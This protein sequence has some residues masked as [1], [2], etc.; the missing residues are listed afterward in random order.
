MSKVTVEFQIKG[1]DKVTTTNQKIIKQLVEQ[2]T[3]YKVL[4]GNIDD[5]IKVQNT[6]VE[7]TQELTKSY[8][9]VLAEYKANE[10]ELK[11]LAIAGETT[12][13]RY[14][15]LVQSV[16][17][18]RA[19]LE[20]V[21][22][23]A[24]IN[25]GTF[26]AI[27]GTL[28]GVTAGFT[29]VQGALGILGVESEETE[30]A[31]LKVQSALAL[32]QGIDQFQKAIPAFTSLATLIKGPVVAAFTT[33]RGAII[34]TGIG[35]AV[36]AVGLLIANFD[37]V[38][39]FVSK[40]V[41]S[42]NNL[43][44]GVKTFI[45]I[46]FPL[47][48]I[49]RLVV[50]G[51]QELGIIDDN[52]TRQIRRNAEA[53]VAA[54]ISKQREIR[55]EIELLQARGA[56]QEEIFAAELR[57]INESIFQYEQM[58]IAKGKLNDEEKKDFEAL[59]QEKR[60]LLAKQEKFE[61]D[62]Q[63]RINNQRITAERTNAER[64]IA[65]L[66]DG[67]KKE[68]RLLKL[69]YEQQR[70]EAI[71]NGED[72][73][74]IEQLY[75]KER[76]EIIKKFSVTY[77]NTVNEIYTKLNAITTGSYI[78]EEAALRRFQDKQRELLKQQIANQEIALEELEDNA[79]KREAIDE[80]NLNN[81]KIKL[82]EEKK[83]LKDQLSLIQEKIRVEE[84]FLKQTADPNKS[85]D[86]EES[87]RKLSAKY[88]KTEKELTSVLARIKN[89]NLQE[90]FQKAFSDINKS[91]EDETETLKKFKS[92]LEIQEELFQAQLQ[93]IR[94]E[95]LVD[96]LKAEIDIREKAGQ[97]V[98]QLQ[99]ELFDNEFKIFS[100]NEKRKVRQRAE[101]LAQANGADEEQIKKA[102]EEA[103]AIY[104]SLLGS[105]VNT[106]KQRIKFS[107]DVGKIEKENN[108]ESLDVQ[109]AYYDELNN[110]SAKNTTDRK[111]QEADITKRFDKEELQRQ[112]TILDQKLAAAKEAFG[113]ESEEYKKL[114]LEKA[115]VEKQFLDASLE[116]Q[117]ITQDKFLQLFQQFLST[118]AE[119][120]AA[121][122]SFYELQAAR[123]N[124]FYD[125]EV[126]KNED[127]NNTEVN[128][129]ALTQEEIQNI[130]QRYALQ[131][132]EIERKRNEEI[133]KIEKQ[134]A[135]VAFRLQIAQIIGNG[136]LAVTRAFAELG[137]IAGAVAAA[138]IG[139]TTGAQI[140]T[141]N[142]QRKV[143]QQLEDGGLLV[144]ASHSQ[145]GIPV[146]NT[147]IEVEGNEFVVNKKS[148]AKY[149]PLLEAINGDKSM[150]A[151]LLPR[152]TSFMQNGG[153]MQMSN[154][155][156]GSTV[157]KTYVVTDE[158]TNKQAMTARI[159]RNSRY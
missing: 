37:K 17:N 40:A 89:I 31:L 55:N 11:A 25:K 108:R 100:E 12:S 134:R 131:E 152:T 73:N 103:V 75:S 155:E 69:N 124:A 145:G 157:F 5:I 86:I 115:K 123:T 114:Q 78:V 106:A 44:N 133:K 48:G 81:Q 96:G 159:K 109:I 41:D 154:I 22:K 147:G 107:N 146:G 26:D 42:F 93:A 8:Q 54:S 50:A 9:E 94:V 118:L 140:A 4:E 87:L 27:F 111:K 23:E 3:E 135:D 150:T 43:G 136:A 153:M 105:I 79:K 14:Q 33:L 144:G 139:V 62:E 101:I 20:D 129:Y 64:R 34:A 156:Q 1:G 117:Q 82:N 70:R 113:E 116:Q 126:R 29:A 141:A 122:D 84:I 127:A 46:I 112:K 52:Q 30:K 45:S 148:T 49:L 65:L 61:K 66:D 39:E 58:V 99:L 51:L 149:L 56:S 71:K 32:S 10:K 119:I 38:R 67:L 130:N 72:I 15:E 138:L 47:V 16:G 102:G 104:E 98:L 92:A 53:N 68:L 137:P 132:T 2:N 121:I 128:N 95:R 77:L 97:D 91:I 59:L 158:V 80:K 24:N 120:G 57:L 76:T 110:I 85:A 83:I 36:V 88:K 21:N 74:L 151:P 125:E 142:N 60:V 13:E 143:V 7:S 90:E 18:A 28:G 19:A 6:Q 63:E 35:A